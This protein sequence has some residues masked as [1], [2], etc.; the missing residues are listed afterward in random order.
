MDPLAEEYSF[1][2]PYAYVANNPIKFI[3]WMGMG[4]D[5]W[6][7]GKNGKIYWNKKAVSYE[8]TEDGETF[9]GSNF[10]TISSDGLQTNYNSDG[11]FDHYST[12]DNLLPE[13]KITFDNTVVKQEGAT[14]T[15]SLG[16]TFSAGWI[17]DTEGNS[18]FYFDFGWTS[19]SDLSIGYEWIRHK[20]VNMESFNLYSLTN[21]E[22]I[23][24]NIGS[25][26]EDLNESS[27]WHYNVG[28]NYKSMSSGFSWG[29]FPASFT[30]SRTRL[31]TTGN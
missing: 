18:E 6:V 16:L 28:D 21:G 25:W 8:T 19:G 14:G 10:S 29:P 3:D 1:Q 23:M 15:A 4:P 11:T 22:S 13:I 20:N 12:D 9:L 24:R 7:K 31:N 26:G 17:D 30:K 27:I 5:E 2:T